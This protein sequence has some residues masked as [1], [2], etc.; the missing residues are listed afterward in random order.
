LAALRAETQRK[1]SEQKCEFCGDPVPPDAGTRARTCSKACSVAWQNAKRQ[2]ARREA[3][4]AARPVCQ[5]CGGPIPESRR[6]GVKY[7]S[8]RCKHNAQAAVWRE[9]APHYMRQYLYGI[10]AEEWA[11]LLERQGGVC[12]ICG[13][14]E[15]PGKDNRPHADHDHVTDRVRGALCGNCNNGLGMFGDDPVRLRAAADYLERASSLA[16]RGS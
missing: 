16:D 5:R 4:L 1:R 7:C 14:G 6:C 9:R 2:A 13:S 3:W 11:A 8:E 12:A 10:T 15:W